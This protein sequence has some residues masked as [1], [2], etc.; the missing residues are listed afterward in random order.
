[1]PNIVIKT[2]IQELEK[3]SRRTHLLK[4]ELLKT[5]VTVRR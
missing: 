5:Y 2:H 1:M 4:I 3:L